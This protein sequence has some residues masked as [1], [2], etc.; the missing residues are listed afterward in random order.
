MNITIY[1]PMGRTFT[2]KDVEVFTNNETALEFSYLAMSD[3]ETKVGHFIKQNI[4]GWSEYEPEGYDVDQE[5]DK[6]TGIS[7]V[8]RGEAP[9]GVTMAEAIEE[10]PRRT[11]TTS[12]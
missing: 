8:T 4:V 3:G 10:M 12:P 5:M 2:F 7:E 9:R 1:T 6:F 11:R